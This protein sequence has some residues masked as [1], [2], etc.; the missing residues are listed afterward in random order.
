LPQTLAGLVPKYLPAVP[1]DPY[2][3]KP[4]RYR[5][6]AG[7]KIAQ[8]RP[9]TYESPNYN[10]P[11]IGQITGG[12]LQAVAGLAGGVVSWPLEPGW[13]E[14]LD[15]TLLPWPVPVNPVN[16]KQADDVAVAPGQGILW[17][18]GPDEMD[19]LGTVAIDPSMAGQRPAG[20]LV[21][22][23]PRPARPEEK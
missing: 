5:V 7:E 3:G 1:A 9:I 20:D 18:V 19:N 4:F 16:T 22:L 2:D 8:N 21:Y 6:S 10:P 14:S 15:S 12:E 23:I 11:G 17:S 13:D